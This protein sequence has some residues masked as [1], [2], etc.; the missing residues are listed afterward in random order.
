MKFQINLLSYNFI[1]N[2]E[3]YNFSLGKIILP[4]EIYSQILESSNNDLTEPF[5]FKV[6]SANKKSVY[7]GVSNSIIDETA[8]VHYRVLQDLFIEENTI[9][10][11]ELVK[12]VKG[13]KVIFQPS[14][15][16]FLE[17]ENH[18]EVLENNLV[19]NYNALSVGSNITIEYQDRL[20]DIQV[21]KLEP[22]DAVS[23]YNTDLEVDFLEP[24]NFYNDSHAINDIHKI[25]NNNLLH[26]QCSAN[27][28][29]D[30]L[31]QINSVLK[32]TN[33][34]IKEFKK[35]PSVNSS[36]KSFNKDNFEPDSRFPGKGNKL[37]I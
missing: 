36:F 12:L 20:Y 2:P 1:S 21:T 29:V 31:N 8:Y 16:D 7:L 32:K 22:E 14:T 19:N 24:A 26:N 37:G 10:E 11:L 6:T 33:R 30:C 35:I 13:N 27:D 17:I 18:K 4:N 34:N 3:E 28:Y 15:K 9:V 5:I 23:L 25:L